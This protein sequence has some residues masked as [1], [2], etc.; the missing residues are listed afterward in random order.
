MDG[1]VNALTTIFIGL[2][3][4]LIS[5]TFGVAG[6]IVTTPAIR[7][8]LGGTPAVALGTPL[9]VTIPSAAAG[10][11]VYARKKLVEWRVALIC[12]LAGIAGTFTGSWIT[13]MVNLHYLMIITALIVI[14][15]AVNLIIRGIRREY[16]PY[17][18]SSGTCTTE[19]STDSPPGIPAGTET[20]SISAMV[21]KLIGVGYGGGFFS[22]LL[23]MGGGIIFV[24]S[25]IFLLDLPIKKAFGTSLA[26]I[27]MV[28]IPG[29]IIH[30][31]LGHIDPL[32]FLY[33]T[34]GVIPGA[35]LG[36]RFSTWAKEAWLYSLFGLFLCCS[37]IIFLINEIMSLV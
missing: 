3:A 6:G 13:K 5:G 29:S 15:V 19:E 21:L 16:S 28:A 25:F 10:C 9:A 34:I 1:A 4:G 22:G 14:Y 23:G 11:V 37:G 18:E 2:F 7:L 24:P 30:Y 32:L 33:L 8:L 20:G 35:Y 17:E 12:G 26:V 31:Y 36:A 27:T